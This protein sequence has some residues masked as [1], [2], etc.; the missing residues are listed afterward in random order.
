[1]KL[2]SFALLLAIAAIGL[3]SSCAKLIDYKR[4]H[5][6]GGEHPCRITKFVT[7]TYNTNGV[8]GSP[9]EYNISYNNKGNPVLLTTNNP[10]VYVIKFSYDNKDRLKEY[11][12]V[13]F[14]SPIDSTI[15]SVDHYYYPPGGKT[16]I[17][18]PFLLPNPNFPGDYGGIHKYN[19][20][21]EGRVIR[22]SNIINNYGVDHID[23]FVYNAGGNLDSIKDIFFPS[24]TYALPVYDNKVNWRQSNKVWQLLDLNYSRNN[25]I[26][27]G[28][29]VTYNQYGLPTQLVRPAIPPDYTIHGARPFR[30]VYAFGYD[31]L[32]IYYACD[33][34]QAY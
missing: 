3:F 25:W 8:P 5:P 28:V 2:T 22:D 1:M 16:I 18:T 14:H 32:D 30:N 34:P 20:D 13:E 27:P 17:D 29:T 9:V 12:F 11:R 19:L 7:R 26:E 6:G 24:G 33:L 10:Y 15:I 31:I 21:A 23:E 4:H